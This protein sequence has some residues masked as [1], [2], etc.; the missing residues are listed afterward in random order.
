MGKFSDVPTLCFIARGSAHRTARPASMYGPVWDAIRRKAREAGIKLGI[1]GP[2][3]NADLVPRNAKRC[4]SYYD[5]ARS[6]G[7]A[8][9]RRGGAGPGTRDRPFQNSS[10]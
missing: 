1:N 6:R 4:V 7:R 5:Y 10:K 8:I 3:P 9:E 2:F